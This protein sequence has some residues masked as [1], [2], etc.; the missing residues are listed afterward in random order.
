MKSKKKISCYLIGDSNLTINCA[1]ALSRSQNL[2]G[3]LSKNSQL[4]EWAASQ[5]IYHTH[6]DEKFFGI[7]KNRNFDYLF[8]VINYRILTKEIIESPRYFAINYHNAPLPRYGGL[9]AASWAILNQE[10][11]HGITW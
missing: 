6:V 4:L 2:L 3:I 11:E 5:H 10:K 8:S 9:N 1:K 7:L